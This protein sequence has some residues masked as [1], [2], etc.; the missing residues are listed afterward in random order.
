MLYS[1]MLCAMLVL[2]LPSEGGFV[3]EIFYEAFFTEY[4][5]AICDIIFISSSID[6]RG[7]VSG[8]GSIKGARW[9]LIGRKLSVHNVS[10]SST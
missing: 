9:L 7:R 4:T 8:N 1:E 3:V 2:S 5:D 10:D 6:V